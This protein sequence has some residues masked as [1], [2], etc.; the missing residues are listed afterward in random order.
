M[1]TRHCAA[2]LLAL[3]LIT[4]AASAQDRASLDRTCF[5]EAGPYTPEV[6][7]A[8]DV[9][10]VYGVGD[11]FAGR[12]A[13]WRDKGY[14]VSLMTGIAWGEYGAYYGSGDAFKRAEVQTAK[15][16]KLYLHGGQANV[17]YNVPTSAYLEFIKRYIDP[18]LD[19][20]IQGLYLEEP[21]YW[22]E[23]GWS[24]AFQQAWEKA[25]DEPWRPPDSSVDAQ[26]KASKLKYELYFEALKEVFGYAKRRAAAQGRTV[27]CHVPTHSLIN[28]A[29]WRI[30]SPEAHLSDLADFDGYVAQVWTGTA[31][32]PNFYRGVHK[33]RTFETAFLEYSQMLAMARPTG[34][35]LW[36]LAD[37]VEDN[38]NRSWADY[39]R[40]YECT[41][42]A[43]LLWPEVHRFEVMPWPSRIFRGQYP[44]VDLD[45]KTDLREGIPADYATEIL[46]VINALNDMNQAEVAYDCGTRGVGVLVSDTLM[47]QRANPE[48]SDPDLGSFYGLALPPLKHG[49]P[50]EAVQ[51]ENAVRPGCLAP[52]RIL[53][54]TYE[55]QKPLKPEYHDALSQWVR[56]G[57]GLVYVGDGADPYHAV[58]EWWNEEG[59]NAGKPE[60][61]LFGRLG[62]G[63]EAETRPEAVGQGYARI[64]RA[65]PAALQKDPAGADRVMALISEMAGALKL[66]LRTQGHLRI[67]RGPYVVAAVLDESPA[68]EPLRLEGGFVD[69]FD[70]GLPVLHEKT[71]RENERALLYDV[72]WGRAHAAGPAVAAAST[73][74]RNETREGDTFSFIARGPQG[75]RAKVR[76][77]LPEAPQE[78]T[79]TP[80][81]PFELDTS[82]DP[83]LPLLAFDNISADVCVRMTFGR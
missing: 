56:D 22:A 77:L 83:K 76:L 58:R 55:G 52:Y 2:G 35:K 51:L 45:T 6:D 36:F 13:V 11:D 26:Y 75:T 81:Q 18:A 16:G 27:E 23:T 49:L 66:G 19:F 37:P 63:P 44:R 5:Q 14:V 10:I 32:T 61:D 67:Q 25:Y 62:V 17:G 59:R 72:A 57:G 21:E 29:Q 7:V 78:V 8:S 28:Y 48:P 12:A 34:K 4:G 71:L 41:V 64:C 33:E 74:I 1:L 46:A 73:R 3:L 30:V 79:L 20:G 82:G 69:L 70:P 50:V 54:L 68:T 53:L 15:S 60:D 47:F 80:P 24:E 39:Q 43:S 31:R 9:A 42:T 38:P 65:N 40:N